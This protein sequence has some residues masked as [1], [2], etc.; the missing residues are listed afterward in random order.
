MSK[1]TLKVIQFW[2]LIIWIMLTVYLAYQKWPESYGPEFGEF[3]ISTAL[4]GLTPFAI[5]GILLF[6]QKS[7]SLS[8]GQR[9][10]EAKTAEIESLHATLRETLAAKPSAEPVAWQA[11]FTDPGQKWGECTKEHHDLVKAHPGEWPG[12]EVRELYAASPAL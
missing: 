3:L 5:V 9:A 1:K 11:R 8:L 10:S 2:G 6:G 12:Y 4:F 7:I